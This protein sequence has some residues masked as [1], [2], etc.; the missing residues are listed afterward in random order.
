METDFLAIQKLFWAIMKQAKIDK[1]NPR[2]KK[3]VEKFLK[4]DWAKLIKM[5]L[6]K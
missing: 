3:S 5:Y 2:Y 4:S 6:Q 1:K